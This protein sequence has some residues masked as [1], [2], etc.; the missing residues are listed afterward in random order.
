MHSSEHAELQS[1][2]RE[3]VAPGS[4]RSAYAKSHIG[5]MAFRNLFPNR[6]ASTLSHS[7]YASQLHVF[8]LKSQFSLTQS[9]PVVL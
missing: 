7:R 8:H 9:V 6:S 1:G 2:K 3:S 5:H 4:V